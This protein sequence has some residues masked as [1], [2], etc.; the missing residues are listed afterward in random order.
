M[1]LGG[2]RGRTRKLQHNVGACGWVSVE[3]FVLGGSPGCIRNSLVISSELP[4]C[5]PNTFLLHA[6]EWGNH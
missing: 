1:T 4:F 2:Y 6:C 3:S 5:L